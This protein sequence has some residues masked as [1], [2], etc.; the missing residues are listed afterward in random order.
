MECEWKWCLCANGCD[1]CP[2]LSFP[3]CNLD[4]AR[5][6]TKLDGDIR[7]HLGPWITGPEL[8]ADPHW[9][10]MWERSREATLRSFPQKSRGRGALAVWSLQWHTYTQLLAALVNTHFGLL[11]QKRGMYLHIKVLGISSCRPC[12]KGFYFEFSSQPPMK[13]VADRHHFPQGETEA[14]G[15]Q[16]NCWK[17][18]NWWAV[19]PS[20]RPRLAV[21]GI[22]AV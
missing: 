11:I 15:D 7:R 5:A 18:G 21:S 16:R 13:Q 8:Q 4:D 22:C 2:P 3:L 17:A 14:Q 19:D 6:N 1:F 9:N 20:W 10:L 12:T